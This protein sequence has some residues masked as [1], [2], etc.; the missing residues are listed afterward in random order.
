MLD[1]RMRGSSHA[2]AT[3]GGITWEV[4]LHR[5]VGRKAMAA[6]AASVLAL[7]AAACGSSSPSSSGSQA[8]SSGK[9][10][11]IALIVDVTGIY[12]SISG[13][14]LYPMEAAIA[15][16]N[17]KGG[18]DGYHIDYKV[19]DSQ[20]TPVG[21]LTA[22]R[23][24]IADHVFAVVA[25]STGLMGGLATL[26]A[27]KMPVIGDGDVPQWNAG[28]TLFSISGDITTQ[29]TTAWMKVL[30]SRGDKR[31]AVPGG[32]LNVVAAQNWSK[33]I[34]YAGGSTC[35]YRVGIDGTDTASITALAHE[36][37][38]AH[39]QGVASPTMYPGTLQLQ[40]ALN[41]LGANIPVVDAGDFGPSVIT[42]AG[43]SADNLIY[44][45]FFASA[46]D[47]SDPGVAQYLAAMK[48][49]EPSQ[50]PYCFCEKGYPIAEWF[51]H[52][53]S[54]IHGTPT[55]TKLVAALNSTNGYTVNGLV[56]PIYEP[57]FH[58]QGSLCLS[59]STIKNG[60]WAPL[61]PGPDPFICGKRLAG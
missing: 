28:P 35:F 57:L 36:I 26:A 30:I 20:S 55:Q 44:A 6:V 48:K 53:L 51:L 15:Q 27:A 3:P 22:A 9:T 34:P 54:Q 37:I 5:S 59:Y 58:T 11:N 56:G 16:A 12:A 2:D 32:T 23:E 1:A 43:S 61:I 4:S 47:T 60:A 17:A 18:V 40:I 39:C 46:Y 19:I 10:L 45:N 14:A 41:Q 21:G 24:A 13:L 52:A 31:I 8:D 50:S 7:S 38:A 42:Q 29:N 25:D 49:Y 33:L